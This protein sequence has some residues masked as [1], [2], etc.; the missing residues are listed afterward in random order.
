MRDTLRSTDKRMRELDSEAAE[1]FETTIVENRVFEAIGGSDRLRYLIDVAERAYQL[2]A[3][4][5]YTDDVQQTAFGAAEDLNDHV[6]EIVER[7]VARECATII[8]D[9][10]T[11]WFDHDDEETVAAAVDEATDWLLDHRDAAEAAGID[12]DDAFWDDED[13]T[14]GEEVSA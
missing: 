7:E 8:K 5:A 9:A 14:A 6:T 1:P 11:G 2:D 4:D 3:D 12:V 13:R 10:R